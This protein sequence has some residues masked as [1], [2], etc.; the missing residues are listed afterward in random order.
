MRKTV[1]LWADSQDDLTLLSG[2][3]EQEFGAQAFQTQ[4]PKPV[5]WE[6]SGEDHERFVGYTDRVTEDDLAHNASLRYIAKIDVTTEDGNVALTERMKKAVTAVSEGRA[7]P[8]VN[9]HAVSIGKVLDTE[10]PTEH[11]VEAETATAKPRFRPRGD[12]AGTLTAHL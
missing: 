7:E 2:T 10:Q 8:I 1:T 5:K 9:S 4:A 6:N 12:D 3:L 11:V